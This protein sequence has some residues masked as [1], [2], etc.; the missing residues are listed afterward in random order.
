MAD[1]RVH[2][3]LLLVISLTKSLESTRLLSEL[4]TCG[5]LECET[6]ISR[7]LATRDYRGPD[8][9]YLNFTKGEE[10]SVYV[11]LAGGREDLWAGSK[12]KDFGY[13]PKDA[14]QIEEVFISEEVQVSTKE[15]D[16]LCLFGL[17][18]IFENEDSEVNSDY[19]ETIFPYEEDKDNNFQ[20]HESDFQIKSEF[21][22]TS[23][24][25]W[26]E[27]QVPATGTLDDV[28][29]TRESTFWEEIEAETL[30]QDPVTEEEE[31]QIPEV[32]LVPP[33]ASVPEARGWFGSRREQAEGKAIESM[34]APLQD[35]SL[36]SR[37]MAMV[38]ENSLEEL[39]ND[40]PQVE[41]KQEPNSEFDSLPKKLSELAS[42]S[43]HILKPQAT[44]WFGGGFTS[45]LGF[46]DED[47]ELEL[48]S[49]ESNQ[50]L[51]DVPN[52]I[53]SDEEPTVPCTE[54]L[55][56]KEDSTTSNSSSLNSNWF[57]FGFGM[58][59]F[60]YASEDKIMSDDRKN[61][62]DRS[63]KHEQPPVS[64][65]GSDK[66]EET[67]LIKFMETEDQTDK[68]RV[69]K[70]TDDSDT[71]PYFK[72]FLSNFDNPW[73][74]QNIPK[75]TELYP[76]QILDEDNIIENDET[77][78]FSA[79][80]YPTGNMKV[81]MLKSRCN[82][83]FMRIHEEV[84]SKTPSPKND[85]EKPKIS[86]AAERHTQVEVNGFVENTL[87]SPDNPMSSQNYIP[88][89]EDVFEFQKYLFQIDVYGIMNSAISPI[90]ILKERVSCISQSFEIILTILL[91]I[92][93][94]TSYFS[95][96]LSY[97]IFVGFLMQSLCVP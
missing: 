10:I 52:P 67:E 88:Q 12:G 56:E 20:E 37:K 26:L 97:I 24:S 13:F 11:K 64:K 18:Y 66:E 57:D 49:K 86:L 29:S 7:V 14:V 33:S 81:V 45:Y 3:L 59:G 25:T 48:L 82:M 44:G 9:R 77:E 85:E 69:L 5:D 73:K 54:T 76:K 65:F 95:V 71:L 96:N 61:E 58:L 38:A 63:N 94:A 43:E 21:Y 39:N 72:K 46:G 1:L 84:H 32:D 22:S 34:I 6:L 60:A 79:E 36:Q 27:D 17:S 23:E 15:S 75:E 80:N 74:F 8:C 50:P 83:H 53:S 87:S 92:E 62:G 78:E 70:D 91:S 42:E 55:V 30:E 2:R 28:R 40:E 4:K 68:K 16:F 93:K 51:Q 19:D 41:Y 90:V 35:S 47:M 89:K 31:D